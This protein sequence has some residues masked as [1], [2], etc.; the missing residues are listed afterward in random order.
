MSESFFMFFL[1]RA[2][3]FPGLCNRTKDWTAWRYKVPASL[4]PPMKSIKAL[5]INDFGATACESDR[6]LCKWLQPVG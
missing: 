5:N 6:G 3:S 4:L 1:S 2:R